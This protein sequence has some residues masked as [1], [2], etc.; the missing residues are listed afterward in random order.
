MKTMKKAMVVLLAALAAIGFAACSAL[1]APDPREAAGAPGE[2]AVRV[3]IAGYETGE[4]TL[5]PAGA[6]GADLVSF[7]IALYQD[8]TGIYKTFD[9]IRPEELGKDIFLGQGTWYLTISAYLEGNDNPVAATADYVEV[10]VISG[11]VTNIG[12][13]P[14]K[15]LDTGYGT[16]AW[17]MTWPAEVETVIVKI[18][19]LSG[20][21]INVP[22]KG[23]NGLL[24]KGTG[25]GYPPPAQAGDLTPGTPGD[26]SD[27]DTSTYSFALGPGSYYITTTLTGSLGTVTRRDALQ[28]FPGRTTW[29]NAAAGYAF[30]GDDFVTV[31]YVTRVDG[32]S[33]EEGT[34]EWA[35]QNVPDGGTVQVL[36]PPGTVFNL[37]YSINI[38]K[39]LTFEGNGAVLTNPSGLA[40]NVQGDLG[41]SVTLRRIHFKDNRGNIGGAINNSGPY[42]TVESCIFSGN[43]SGYDGGAIYS[44]GDLILRGNTF[45]NNKATGEYRNGGAVY[46]SSESELYLWG[47]VFYGNTATQYGNV[48]YSYGTVI[49]LGGNVSDY[50]AGNDSTT[51]SGFDADLDDIFEVAARPFSPVSYRPNY[52]SDLQGN[53][54]FSDSYPAYDFYG[55]PIP[56]YYG[57]T[58]AAGAVQTPSPA[59]FYSVASSVN[60]AVAGS[61]NVNVDQGPVDGL[62]PI[63]SH[64]TVTAAPTD[65]SYYLYSLTVNGN[66]EESPYNTTLTEDLEIQAVFGRKVVVTSTADSGRD[67]L[68]SAVDSAQDYDLITLEVEH[69]TITLTGAPLSITK[70]ITLNGN[71]LTLRRAPD[72]EATSNGNLVT[73]NVGGFGGANATGKTITLQQ[74]H[75]TGGRNDSSGGGAIFHNYGNLTVESC[76]FSDNQAPGSSGGDI[77]KSPS[78][79]DGGSLTLLGNTFYNNS[80]P[81]YGGAVYV[82]NGIAKL[83]GN[84]FF[85][86]TSGYGY[87]V[88]YLY[89]SSLQSLGYNVSDYAS[90]SSYS[91]FDFV[92]EDT[93]YGDPEDPATSPIDAATFAPTAAARGDIT[94]VPD[95]SSGGIAGYPAV[96]FNGATRTTYPAAAGAVN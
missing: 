39:S 64:V 48:V 23:S 61:V 29:A 20:S 57:A 96:D 62:Y 78:G 24:L 32:Y 35:V 90:G 66:P 81:Y 9:G 72:Y 17:D 74:I 27:P 46:T 42:L 49:S 47:N 25:S 33:Y 41:N 54:V 67:T 80:T 6:T 52:V 5:L 26:P 82:G 84:I 88:V 89:N 87:N 60:D 3:S 43:H 50:A 30:T 18:T 11:Q 79:G 76:I 28:I 93:Q 55:E 75:F 95:P 36:L 13:V 91:G 71:G 94:I 31:C 21:P 7:D 4:R 68:R 83:G 12:P 38:S 22:G 85:G 10:N 1:F 51:G 69:A 58:A 40:I 53:V 2:G 70:S 8:G 63:G 44:S 16:F 14:L 56:Y 86:N 77:L 19:N 65:G 59:G 92:F 34:L 45:Y 15:T 73:F 37:T